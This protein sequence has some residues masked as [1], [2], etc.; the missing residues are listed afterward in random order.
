MYSKKEIEFV[1]N[2]FE[3]IEEYEKCNDI[4]IFMKNRFDH[5]KGFLKQN[6]DI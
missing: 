5:K 4:L 3:K 6:N 2:Y 1:L